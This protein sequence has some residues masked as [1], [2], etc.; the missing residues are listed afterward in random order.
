[1]HRNEK[2][3]PGHSKVNEIRR[4]KNHQKRDPDNEAKRG[5]SGVQS[6]RSLG[7]ECLKGLLTS[8]SKS[9]VRR[10]NT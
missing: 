3:R 7:R 9:F 4:M 8:V 5:V 1:V 10:G 2:R 6:S